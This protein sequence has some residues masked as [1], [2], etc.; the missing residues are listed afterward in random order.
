MRTCANP[1]C[2]KPFRAVQGEQ[3]YCCSPCRRHA[4]HL[5]TY[6]A[7]QLITA[8]CEEC[9]QPYA[10]SE[11]RKTHRYCSRNCQARAN[12]RQRLARK[13]ANNPPVYCPVCGAEVKSKLGGQ[14]CSQKHAILDWSWKQRGKPRQGD[15]VRWQWR[16]GVVLS[17]KV[18]FRQ[19]KVATVLVA[20]SLHEVSVKQLECIANND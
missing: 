12:K 15:K 9:H 5:R 19:G 3:L 2:G 7:A 11:R 14:Y 10:R 20:G 6:R 13:R 1:E 8:T 4:H 16:P 18:Q 17:G